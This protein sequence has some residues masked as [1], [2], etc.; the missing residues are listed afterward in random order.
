MEYSNI[1]IKESNLDWI[2]N[3]NAQE[4]PANLIEIEDDETTKN[5]TA[6]IDMGPCPLQTLSGLQEDSYTELEIGTVLG[7]LLAV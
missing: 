4:L 1:E 6:S 2:E 3:D 5:L 7:L